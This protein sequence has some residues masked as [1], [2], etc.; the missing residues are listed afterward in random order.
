MSFILDPSEVADP[1]R[2]ELDL[3]STSSAIQ[4]KPE[5][6]DWGDT[7]L[8]IQ[9]G[10]GRYGE[11]PLDWRLPNRII[12]APLVMKSIPAGDTLIT[13]LGKLQAKISRFA[14]EG[15]T[16]KRTRNSMKLFRRCRL[17]FGCHPGYVDRRKQEL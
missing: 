8:E 4:V 6:I 11:S 1:G 9:K 12:R 15:G 2:V 13:G 5:G 16:L 3:W 17:G 7:A 14:T 10:S